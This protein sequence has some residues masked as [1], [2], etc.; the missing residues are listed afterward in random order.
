MQTY[1]PRV[2]DVVTILVGIALLAVISTRLLGEDP[3][4]LP[5]PNNELVG[6]DID[7]LGS[8]D[9]SAAARSLIMVLR[10]DCVFCQD[11]MPFY[12]RL[13]AEDRGDAQIVV[14]AP[15]HDTSIVDYLASE[16]VTPD[17]IIFL[18]SGVLP[19]QGT[20]TLLMVD[21]DGVVT[22]AWLG[23]LNSDRE[24]DVI[25]ILFD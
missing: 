6:Q 10:S 4:S 16:S 8:I 19:V 24:A 12:R 23:L 14:A 25:E 5:Q 17:S 11:S 13:V 15:P 20:P 3:L 22:H 7:A 9:F 1:L 18:E 21:R 2:A